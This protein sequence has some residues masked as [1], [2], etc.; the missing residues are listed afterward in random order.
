MIKKVHQ[1][2]ILKSY[3]ANLTS[4]NINNIISVRWL[5]LLVH[6]KHSALMNRAQNICFYWTQHV[7]MQ[8]QGGKACELL[9]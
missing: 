6:M 1:N 4:S 5:D 2:S 8:V 3:Y 7:H 9:A